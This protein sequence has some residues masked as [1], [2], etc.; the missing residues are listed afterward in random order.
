MFRTRLRRRLQI[1]CSHRGSDWGGAHR[2][3]T[4]LSGGA[5]SC[6]SPAPRSQQPAMRL[7][8]HG[9]LNMLRVA[10]AIDSSTVSTGS[11]QRRL[12]P[13]GHGQVNPFTVS[14]C[15]PDLA[16]STD[17]AVRWRLDISAA[18]SPSSS[19]CPLGWCGG[20]LVPGARSQPSAMRLRAH[21]LHDV[22][23][24]VDATS[25]S[26]VPAGSA[27]RRLI[28]PGTAR[29]TLS[30]SPPKVPTRRLHTAATNRADRSRLGHDLCG[31][32]CAYRRAC[33][34]V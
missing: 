14:I 13:T 1:A 16:F 28:R 5:A 20:V 9:L 18:S 21:G 33:I 6:S 32:A 12:D 22:L 17:S 30:R 15:G 11:E 26:T 4:A 10:N 25:S 7:Q 31:L 23:H 34:L 24:V 2:R 19:N 27:R 3:P 8:A 29:R